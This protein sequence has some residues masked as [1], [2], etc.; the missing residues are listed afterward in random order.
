MEDVLDLYA[1]PYDAR[2]PKVNCDE[3]NVQLIAETQ[4]FPV[5]Q[6]Q[7]EERP[8]RRAETGPKRR[9]DTFSWVEDPNEDRE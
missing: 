7:V 9:T 4:Q 6:E 2:R 8:R 5:G 3:K 1:E